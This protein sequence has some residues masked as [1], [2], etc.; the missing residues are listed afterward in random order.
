MAGAPRLPQVWTA[1]QR[2]VVLGIVV[3]LL[4][5]LTVQYLRNPI[6]VSDPQPPQGSRYNELADRID[7]NTADQQTLASLPTM[8]ERR[9]AAI[10]AYRQ[11]HQR[12]YPDGIFF[13][14]PR[15]LLKLKGF[16]VATVENLQPYLM[17]PR[18][19]KTHK[20]PMTN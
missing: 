12:E 5:Y 6:S 11:T 2:R 1:R 8:G 13:R 18:D 7:P 9:A 3:V 4:A 14:Q 19:T 20:E 17:F 15:D 10:V 16:G